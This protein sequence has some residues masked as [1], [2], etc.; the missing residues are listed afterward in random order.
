VAADT[1]RATQVVVSIRMALRAPYAGMCP[2]QWKPS[3]RMI[4]GRRLPCCC[5]VTNFALLRKSRRDVI[6]I[7]GSL[8][9]LQ[10]AGHTR[11]RRQVVVPV[12]VALR[13]SHM[14]VGP[15]QWECGFRV[16]ESCRLP[17]RGGVTHFALL[18]NTGGCVIGVGRPLEIPEVARNTR[19][20]R[21]VEIAI[22][23]TLIAL[24]LRVSTGER[25]ADRIVIEAGRLPSGG[26]M[27]ILAALRESE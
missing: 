20:R 18:G 1:S 16:V 4:E 23:V 26:R 13:A 25:K 19:R 10:V 11:S 9:I 7:R 12:R 14:C 27:T 15:S 22:C 24:Q 3:L 6:R 8:K 2:C 17:T 5:G 21:E